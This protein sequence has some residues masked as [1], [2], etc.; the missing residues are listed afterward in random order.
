MY[1]LW[2]SSH[3]AGQTFKD[4]HQ[5]QLF[6]MY[7]VIAP[8]YLLSDLNPTGQGRVCKGW[9]RLNRNVHVSKQLF[10]DFYK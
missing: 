6:Y 8:L 5:C 1:C 9:W 4:I 3:Y 7:T 10:V 2:N